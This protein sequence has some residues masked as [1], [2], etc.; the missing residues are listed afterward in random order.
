MDDGSC[1]NDRN[2]D[3]IYAF[4]SIWFE[5]LGCQVQKENFTMDAT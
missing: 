2:H 5:Q 1:P 4:V 3:F